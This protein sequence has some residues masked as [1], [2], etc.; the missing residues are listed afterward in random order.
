MNLARLDDCSLVTLAWLL[1]PPL[2]GHSAP[3]YGLGGGGGAGKLPK[4][5]EWAG[6]LLKMIHSPGR[7]LWHLTG[8]AHWQWPGT[9]NHDIPTCL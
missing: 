4:M 1:T 3:W 9:G 6:H 5:V 8:R 2:R 7:D